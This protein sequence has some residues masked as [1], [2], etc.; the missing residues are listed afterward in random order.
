[1][2]AVRSG[3]RGGGCDS[4]RSGMGVRTVGG[5][6]N[7]REGPYSYLK[8]QL[9]GYEGRHQSGEPHAVCA[10]RK[11]APVGHRRRKRGEKGFLRDGG[12]KG[13][14]YWPGTLIFEEAIAALT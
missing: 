7:R 4:I 9:E 13:G 6:V 11:K 12:K 14:V 10:P 2:S 5:P 1:M 3:F 8:T